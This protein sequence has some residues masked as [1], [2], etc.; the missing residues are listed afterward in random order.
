M[1][2][3]IHI[4]VEMDPALLEPE[5]II[6][7]DKKS[8]LTDR[9]IDAIERCAGGGALK[10]SASKDN[11]AFLLNQ[12]D[13]IR[14]YKENRRLMVCASSGNYQSRL[15][16]GEIEEILLKDTFVQISRF[17]I[18][19]INKIASFDMSITGTI[20]IAFIDGSETWVARRYMRRIQEKLEKFGGV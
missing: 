11:K 14:V 5:I 13:I 7:A 15:T 6:K 1:D 20:K 3:K 9:L 12:N 18:V 4:S 2:R 19:N 8:G 17:E 10:I 16:L